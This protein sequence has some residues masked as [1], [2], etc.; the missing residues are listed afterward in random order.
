MCDQNKNVPRSLKLC[1]YVR[2]G[3][4]CCVYG[5]GKAKTSSCVGSVCR[6]RAYGLSVLLV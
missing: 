2:K 3:A 1:N 4:V 5:G 6:A